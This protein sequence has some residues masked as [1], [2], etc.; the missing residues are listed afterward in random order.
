M[1]L[2]ILRKLLGWS[3]V[4]N[5]AVLMSWFL[6]FWLAHD[7]FY[8]MHK[9]WFKL[10]AEKFVTINYTLMGMY[11]ILIFLLFIGPYLAIRIVA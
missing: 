6:A 8:G 9:K 5:L 2:E 1:E 4:I 7:W 11:E 3:A 10:P